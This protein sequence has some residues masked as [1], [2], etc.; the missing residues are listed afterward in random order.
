MHF[1]SNSSQW[2]CTAFSG[3]LND[4]SYFD[5]PNSVASRT[6][7]YSLPLSINP[8]DGNVTD[9]ECSD[10][11]KFSI[12]H[13]DSGFTLG[14][15]NSA[16]SNSSYPPINESYP[17]TLDDR[18]E[19]I[20][21]CAAF[22]EEI[23]YSTF[24]TFFTSSNWTCVAYFGFTDDDSEFD[25]PNV[26]A[27]EVYGYSF[28]R[29]GSPPEEDDDCDFD[30]WTSFYNGTGFYINADN[31]A[32]DDNNTAREQ[33]FDGSLSDCTA[34]QACIDFADA[35][36]Y[37]TVEIEQREN[38]IPEW[39]CRIFYGILTNES[40]FSEAASFISRAY[41][42][43]LPGGPGS[44]ETQE[45]D[46]PSSSNF[47]EFYRGPGK[48]LAAANDAS[49][50]DNPSQKTTLEDIDDDCQAIDECIDF[51]Q[52][53]DYNT[54]DVHHVVNITDD[55]WECI[56]YYGYENDTTAFSVANPSVVIAY[57]FSFPK[58]PDTKPPVIDP[59]CNVGEW[60]IFYNG[61]N[62]FL[63]D[64]NPANDDP[65][66]FQIE[67][68]SFTGTVSVCEAVE[69]CQD[70]AASFNY[71]TFNVYGGGSAL[72]TCNMYHGFN[73]DANTLTNGTE[74]ED[75]VPSYAYSLEKIVPNEPDCGLLN[76]FKNYYFGTD[77]ELKSG[78]VADT[79]PGKKSETY[80]ST[81]TKC[82]AIK[83]CQAF[84]DASDYLTFNVFFDTDDGKWTCNAFHGSTSDK[85]EFSV[86]NQYI[87]QGYGYYF[88]KVVV[89]TEP[90]CDE[91]FSSWDNFYFGTG[92]GMNSVNAA[93]TDS[94]RAPKTATYTDSQFESCKII[95]LC[96][97][98]AAGNNYKTIALVF[99]DI[100]DLWTCTAFA[101]TT[102]DN[103]KFNQADTK[104]SRGYG[105]YLQQPVITD[106][107][108][109]NV[110]GLTTFSFDREKVLAAAGE[111]NPYPLYYAPGTKQYPKTLTA[112]A[113]IQQCVTDKLGTY[114]TLQMVFNTAQQE[115]DCTTYFGSTTNKNLISVFDATA[116]PVYALSRAATDPANPSCNTGS[117]VNFYAGRRKTVDA[118]GKPW[119]DQQ[120]RSTTFNL[121]QTDCQAVEACKNYALTY[122]AHTFDV[123]VD[124][125]DNV[126]LCSIYHGY[127]NA[128]NIYSIDDAA[129]AIAYGYSAPVEVP[130]TCATTGSGQFK[131]FFSDTGKRMSLNAATNP[132]N[133]DGTKLPQ[134]RAVI[135]PTT[136]V[137]DATQACIDWTKSKNYATFELVF[138][139][140]V[141]GW[142]CRA[143][144]GVTDQTSA[145]S[146]SDAAIDESFGWYGLAPLPYAGWTEVYRGYD[147]I[148][149]VDNPANSRPDTKA[150]NGRDTFLVSDYPEEADQVAKCIVTV[151][152]YYNYNTMQISI[153]D[154]KL[155]FICKVYVAG[156]PS[157]VTPYLEPVGYES[158]VRIYTKPVSDP[159]C[160]TTWTRLT[161]PKLTGF[162][163]KTGNSAV[164]GRTVETQL[165][166][167]GDYTGDVCESIN[168]CRRYAE[169]EL[170]EYHTFEMFYITGGADAGK[171]RCRVYKGQL[172][173]LTGE[174]VADPNVGDAYIYSTS[175][176]FNTP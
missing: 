136:A 27:T 53:N 148:L 116:D 109:A 92:N 130:P 172:T 70:A 161:N 89:A 83:N 16:N 57:G 111:H 141:P 30:E 120:A 112:C 62:A 106:P 125:E 127:V 74:P 164:G 171:R 122:H 153:S 20:Q 119:N 103:T 52:S 133:S 8:P 150:P 48:I 44:N 38:D 160:F 151:A 12:F 78:N 155:E 43:S 162:T 175:Q 135:P 145:F 114:S 94:S 137:C 6:F 95:D 41:G 93:N 169:N 91:N 14:T 61:R 128:A 29:S 40:Y 157:D 99:D 9:P 24:E 63:P 76:G 68:T 115:W 19:V 101:G 140:S 77:F 51:A 13:F 34:I 81:T 15:A 124:T 87:T 118:V 59:L 54:I 17:G 25:T 66:N 173:S 5:T 85:T 176:N 65:T 55:Y 144:S 96:I 79:A 108:C 28:S 126:W 156:L 134:D 152:G 75:D 132:A 167:V 131:R 86:A 104:I 165:Y 100:A 149:K 37:S 102:N 64:D 88:P 60:D 90:D 163:L 26:D 3:Y 142:K 36:E 129:V 71:H 50:V 105:Y 56:A 39:Y 121:D 23:A 117:Y 31:P 123:H 84:A 80:L 67:R 42:Y 47:T 21:Q 18:C 143:F 49:D 170:E 159:T 7:G 46:D 107:S 98:F 154:N 82:N 33:I 32:N 158:K 110:G 10:I 2:I 97:K 69:S 1:L 22:T 11:G 138:D 73:D 168:A 147:F 58:T 45:C 166:D 174:T 72:W 146:E 4:S 35:N 113:A 139:S